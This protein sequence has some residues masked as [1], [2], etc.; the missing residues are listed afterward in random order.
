M[1]SHKD[2]KVVRNHDVLKTH[3]STESII[4]DISHDPL[5]PSSERILNLKFVLSNVKES[6]QKSSGSPL[7]SR[8]FAEYRPAFAFSITG[9]DRS[10]PIAEIL[11][12]PRAF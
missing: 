10:I 8:S 9:G 11:R 6:G 2:E 1:F 5:Y 7:S 4:P 12:S 3:S